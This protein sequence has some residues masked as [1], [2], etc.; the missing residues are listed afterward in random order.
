MSNF[1]H[2]LGKDGLNR[3]HLPELPGRGWRTG[4]IGRAYYRSP[5]S[6]ALANTSSCEWAPKAWSRARMWFLTVA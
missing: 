1:G 5:S 6:L 3:E 2:L 4:G